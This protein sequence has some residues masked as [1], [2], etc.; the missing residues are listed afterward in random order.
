MKLKM[1][2]HNGET[3]LVV[4]GTW[5]NLIIK[6]EDGWFTLQI[7]DTIYNS[8]APVWVSDGIPSTDAPSTVAGEGL[9]ANGPQPAPDDDVFKR[10]AALRKSISV[11]ENVPP[12]MIFHDKTL[13]EMADKMP[14]DLQAMAKISGVGQAKLDRFGQIFLDVINGIVV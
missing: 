1:M 5:Q 9:P 7:L 13:R 3:T 12:Y 2:E 10:L 11:G 6:E 14:A 4:L 8:E